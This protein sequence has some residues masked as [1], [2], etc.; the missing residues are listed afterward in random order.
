MPRTVSTSETAPTRY[1]HHIR[2]HALTVRRGRRAAVDGIDLNWAPEC[3]V[4]SV[5]TGRARPP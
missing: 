5:P 3:T 4:C 1:A 2:A